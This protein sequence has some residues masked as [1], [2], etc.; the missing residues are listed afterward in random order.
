MSRKVVFLAVAVVVAGLL[1]AVVINTG[2]SHV[3]SNSGSSTSTVAQIQQQNRSAS[4]LFSSTPY[5]AYSYQIYPGAVSPQ[6]KSAMD[7]YSMNISQ[8]AAGAENITISV[9]GRSGTIAITSGER[10]YIVETSFGDDAPGYEGSVGDDGFVVADQ[11]G[12]VLS[13]FGI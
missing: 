5:Y 4:V 12:Y 3:P 13:A 7:G 9:Q 1:A 2:L 11:N 8:A 6:A 10:L